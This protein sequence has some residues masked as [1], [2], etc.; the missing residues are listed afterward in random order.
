[1]YLYLRACSEQPARC[2]Y[3]PPPIWSTGIVD[4]NE[5]LHAYQAWSS[6]GGYIAIDD[7]IY[8]LTY[9]LHAGDIVGAC[10]L[11]QRDARILAALQRDNA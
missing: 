1:M 10:E 11:V 2:L 6:G 4:E 7:W 8:D 9:L 5:S 3:L